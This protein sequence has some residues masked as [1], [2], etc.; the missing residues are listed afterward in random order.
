MS[1]TTVLATTSPAEAPV[2]RH[3]PDGGHTL[4]GLSARSA[5]LLG[6]IAADTHAAAASLA[7]LAAAVTAQGLATKTTLDAASITAF[8][9]AMSNVVAATIQPRLDALGQQLADAGKRIAALETTTGQTDSR[10]AALRDE[11]MRLIE[12]ECRQACRVLALEHERQHERLLLIEAR[13][14]PDDDKPEPSPPASHRAG[15]KP[16]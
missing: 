9:T 4:L 13:F 16:K 10:V 14:S 12:V 1:A 6:D 5:R 3:D 8:A 15:A 7:G 2:D 11:I